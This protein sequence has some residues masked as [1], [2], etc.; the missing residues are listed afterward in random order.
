MDLLGKFTFEPWV[1]GAAQASSFLPAELSIQESLLAALG[2]LKPS[3]RSPGSR[4][5]ALS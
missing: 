2:Y 4:S 5:Y 3:A 1:F